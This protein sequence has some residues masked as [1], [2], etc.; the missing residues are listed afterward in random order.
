[1]YRHVFTCSRVNLLTKL[2]KIF[3]HSIYQLDMNVL[4]REDVQRML[5]G[6]Y[7]HVLSKK[8]AV[9]KINLFP[10][11]DQDTGSNLVRTLRGVYD[12]IYGRHFISMK[13]L[14]HEALEGALMC[15]AGNAGIITTSFLG[16]LFEPFADSE[17]DTPTLVVGFTRGYERAYTSVQDPKAG[18]ILDVMEFTSRQLNTLPKDATI[19]YTFEKAVE[20][21]QEALLKT[22]G[23]VPTYKK[24]EVVDAGGLGFVYLLEGFLFGLQNSHTMTVKTES[25]NGENIGKPLSEIVNRR[26][27]VVSI[28]SDIQKEQTNI[29]QELTAYGDCIDVISINGKMKVHIHTD[30]PNTVKEKLNSWGEILHIKT[31]DM[32]EGESTSGSGSIGII[33][34]EG[35]SIP[36]QYA[37][38]LDIA[39]VPFQFEWDQIKIDPKLADLNIY[40]TM[41]QVRKTIGVSSPPKTS[42]PSIY[43]FV[44]SF[45]DHLQKYESVICITTS[46]KVSGTFNSA[47]QARNQLSQAH[48]ERV[49]I[50]DLQQALAGHAHLVRHA[51]KLVKKKYPVSELLRSLHTVAKDV[52][53][54]GFGSDAYWL[55]KGGRLGIKK[56]K[57]LTMVLKMGIQPVVGVKGGKLGVHGF[58][59]RRSSLA[60]MAYDY[61]RDK[62]DTSEKYELIVHHADNPKELQK[63]K[64]FI[65]DSSFTIVQ[66]AVLSPVAGIHIG[67]DSLVL[68]VCKR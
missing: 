48:K 50:P 34:D 59:K 61:L 19:L 51:V 9:N 17:V 66:D 57:A 12:A 10:V 37:A 49:F 23:K 68:A 18:T 67:P 31:V 38:E 42:Q 4:K 27:E 15:A 1:M 40:E 6:G 8:E 14:T 24:S 46:S 39:V 65:K 33:T 60:Q 25:K 56:A 45:K 29:M 54:F 21:S 58:V 22:K 62:Y 5:I 52:Q 53:V 20:Y 26:F 3:V 7:A 35:S 64:E 63:L 41:R 13:D 55:M 16:G 28:L 44:K 47:L 36:L 11:P 30:V 2:H 43:A 32:N